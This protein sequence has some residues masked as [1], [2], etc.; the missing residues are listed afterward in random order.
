MEEVTQEGSYDSVAAA[1]QWVQL[2]TKA[3]LDELVASYS[4]KDPYSAI[5]WVKLAYALARVGEQARAL[6]TISTALPLVLDS[7]YAGEA[8]IIYRDHVENKVEL[9]LTPKTLEKLGIHLGE[10]KWYSEASWCLY[11]AA[12]LGEGDEQE[13]AIERLFELGE[14]ARQELNKQDAS[15][16]FQM[17]VDKF[18]TSEFAS[19]ANVKLGEM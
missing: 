7:P 12:M 11:F 1:I 6:Q 4:A 9:K 18:E 2:A 8:H 10:Q 17:I 15:A 16:I 5:E 13:D 19:I 14:K 3:E